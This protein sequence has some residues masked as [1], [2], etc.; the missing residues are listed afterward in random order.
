M[1]QLY[2]KAIQ[3]M[4][5]PRHRAMVAAILGAVLVTTMVSADSHLNNLR[6][7]DDPTGRVRTFSTSGEAQV[8]NA[9]FQSLGT[10][11]RS[12]VTCHQASDA[13]TVTPEHIRARFDASNG[14]DP[15]FRTNDGA[16][17]PSADVTTLSARRKSYSMLLNKGLIR[18]SIGVPANAGFA[19]TGIDD[20]Q[21][22][23]FARYVA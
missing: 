10:N 17:C 22:C 19:V 4:T 9:F 13:W 23:L 11:G 7:F 5:S 15:I 3:R 12:C 14:L 18:V 8:N 2:R 1:R 16:N 20:P 6:P 21:N